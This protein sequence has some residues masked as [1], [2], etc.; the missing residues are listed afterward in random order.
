MHQHVETLRQVFVSLKQHTVSIDQARRAVGEYCRERHKE[1]A[2]AETV[3]VE[4]KKVAMP[5]LFEDYA[6][7]ETLVKQCVTDF[8][9]KHG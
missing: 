3:I 1:G 4:V 8:F 9:A 5:I 6:K 2:N 7:I